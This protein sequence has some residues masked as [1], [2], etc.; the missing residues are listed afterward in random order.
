[1][2]SLGRPH[3]YTPVAR[4]GEPATRR[5]SATVSVR[6]GGQLG[7][8]DSTDACCARSPAVA[9]GVCG[10]LGIIGSAIGRLTKVAI[11]PA[12][13][14]D[15]TLVQWGLFGSMMVGFAYFER[16]HC[17]LKSTGTFG[18]A[19]PRTDPRNVRHSPGLPP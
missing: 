4:N 15:L 11:V 5:P 7:S 9:W 3:R 12:L 10:F 14:R 18:T 17:R 2:S 8:R 1:M 16:E 13:Q 19:A 6:F